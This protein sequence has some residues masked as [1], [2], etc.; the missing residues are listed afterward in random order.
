MA[1]SMIHTVWRRTV[2]L[3]SE[4]E[5]SSV[6]ANHDSWTMRHSYSESFLEVDLIPPNFGQFGFFDWA[7]LLRYLLIAFDWARCDVAEEQIHVLKTGGVVWKLSKWIEYKLYYI[8]RGDGENQLKTLEPKNC[9]SLK[10]E[11]ENTLILKSTVK[12]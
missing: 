6:M 4:F 9:C 2:H 11:P 10:E 1:R 8:I 7:N 3:N 5:D 12:L